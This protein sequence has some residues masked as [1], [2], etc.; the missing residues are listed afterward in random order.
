MCQLWPRV[1]V[2]TTSLRQTTPVAAT[3]IS[4]AELVKPHVADFSRSFFSVFSATH[5]LKRP[6]KTGK[7]Q[8][9]VVVLPRVAGQAT[10]G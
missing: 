6:K 7:T 5:G 1:A 8:P 9:R 3:F 2:E 10:R 4:S